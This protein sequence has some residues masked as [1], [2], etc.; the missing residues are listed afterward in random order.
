MTRKI[1]NIMTLNINGHIKIN[2]KISKDLIELME[3]ASLDEILLEDEE[4]SLLEKLLLKTLVKNLKR[5]QISEVLIKERPV[6]NFSG[7]ESRVR[8]KNTP[9]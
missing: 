7:A 2:V 5:R 8:N 4:I 6:F 1:Q 3:I 9:T